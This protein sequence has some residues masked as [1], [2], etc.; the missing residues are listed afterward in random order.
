VAVAVCRAVKVLCV[1]TDHEALKALR[2]ATTAAEWELTPGA[3]NETD[4]LGL[5]DSERPHTVVAFGDFERLVSLVRDRFP[6]MRIVTDRDTPWT[7]AV[8]ASRDDVR[9]LLRSLARPGGPIVEKFGAQPPQGS[10]P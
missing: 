4:A 10:Q 5:I 2:Q 6:A 8:A 3:T 1:A 9:E 7:N